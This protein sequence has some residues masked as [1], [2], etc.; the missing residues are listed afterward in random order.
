MRAIARSCSDWVCMPAAVCSAA[1][2]NAV[3]SGSLFQRLLRPGEALSA[4]VEHDVFLALE[5]GE[6]RPGGD[7]GGCGDVGDGGCLEPALQEQLDGRLPQRLARALF[8]PLPQS[9]LAHGVPS[10]KILR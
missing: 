6:E 2:R 4:L 10:Y 5:V 3:S 9:Q 1:R 7:V 8:L